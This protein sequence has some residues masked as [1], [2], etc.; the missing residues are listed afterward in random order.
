MN[1]KP[2]GGYS[3]ETHCHHIDIIVIMKYEQTYFLASGMPPDV[4]KNMAGG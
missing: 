4:N 3:S 2:I 1:T